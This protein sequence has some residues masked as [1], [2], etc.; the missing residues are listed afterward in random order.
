MDLKSF[1]LLAG[2]CHGLVMSVIL[3]KR[4]SQK[5][6]F[7]IL[8]LLSV[9]L[10]LFIHFATPFHRSPKLSLLSYVLIYGYIPIYIL[11][12][13]QGMVKRIVSKTWLLVLPSAAF[14]LACI[15]Y[16]LMPGEKLRYADFDS[17]AIT[18]LLAVLSNVFLLIRSSK[19]IS[20]QN[21]DS[22]PN[23]LFHALMIASS[24]MWLA[25]ILSAG[26]FI[27]L[28]FTFNLNTVFI[29]MSMFVF[30]IGYFLMLPTHQPAKNGSSYEKL[31]ISAT[32]QEKTSALL[33]DHLNQTKP[34]LNPDCSL[35]EVAASLGIEKTRLSFVINKYMHTNFNKLINELRIEEFLS[36]S[37]NQQMEMYDLTGIAQRAGFR[38]KS[39]FYKSF[40]DLYGVSP[41]EYLNGHAPD[42]TPQ[43]TPTKLE[44]L[45]QEK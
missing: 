35:S 45:I 14:L 29:G 5:N 19:V 20:N 40:R 34:Y 1:I 37:Q 13:Q 24:L 10:F 21:P 17:L 38:S 44:G 27:Q 2:A 15:P 32:D 16:L 22:R 31:K 9:S 30:G 25:G 42:I 28:P 7:F 43:I 41:K 36:L 11:H 23:H 18:D 8:L 6:R 4:D 39:T 33:L 12:L 26:D 3:W